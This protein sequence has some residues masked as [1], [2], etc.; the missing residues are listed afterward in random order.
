MAGIRCP[1]VV[2]RGEV[3]KS[4]HG[5]VSS[6]AQAAARVPSV[7]PWAASNTRPPLRPQLA[8]SAHF[9][10]AQVPLGRS[11]CFPGLYH[12]GPFEDPGAVGR[13]IRAFLDTCGTDSA[14]RTPP[15]APHS[16]M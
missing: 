16:R 4:V 15:D 12:L 6:T 11:V 3:V 13:S 10:S 14:T 8:R 9:I 7:P 1:V 5:M 2:A